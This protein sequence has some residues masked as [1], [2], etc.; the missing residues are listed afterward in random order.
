[1]AEF[2]EAYFWK[3]TIVRVFCNSSFSLQRIVDTGLDE[4]L[5]PLKENKEN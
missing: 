1:M 5:Q 4:S 3:F 2:R